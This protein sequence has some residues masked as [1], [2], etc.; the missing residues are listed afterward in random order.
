[1]PVLGPYRRPGPRPGYLR[2]RDGGP[3]RPPARSA[4]HHRPPHARPPRGTP[5]DR[6][7]PDLL[8]GLA[9]GMQRPALRSGCWAVSGPSGPSGAVRDSAKNCQIQASSA[10]RLCRPEPVSGRMRG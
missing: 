5:G 1:V 2:R 9:S 10:R 4:W 8:S 7:L 6:G 3:A